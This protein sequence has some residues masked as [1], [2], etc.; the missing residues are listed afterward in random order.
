MTR[1][2]RLAY[3]TDQFLPSDGADTIQL[4]S[5]TSAFAAA[6][7]AVTLMP[8]APRRNIPDAANV[9]A[10]YGVAPGFGWHPLPGPYPALFRGL[11]KLLH[12]WKAARY[13]RGREID[14]VYTR[15]LPSLLAV[16]LLTGLPVFYE[17]YRPWPAQS[18]A[19]SLLFRALAR[20]RRFAGLI[21]HSALAAGSYAPLGYDEARL[22]VAHNGINPRLFE[23]APSRQEAR[24]RFGFDPDK[25]IAVY[26]G[27]VSPAKGLGL[28]LDAAQ[29]LP[30]LEFVLAGSTGEGAIEQRARGMGNVRVLGWQRPEAVIALLA[31]AD[32]LIIPPTAAPLQRTGNTVLPL[33]TFQYM[34]AGRAIVA[35]ATPDVM[36]VLADGSNARLVPPDQGESFVA[37]LR[38]L[39]ADP[40]LRARLGA[41]GREAALANSWQARAERVAGFIRNRL[42]SGAG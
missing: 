36:E 7:H 5:M 25:I 21:L 9:A 33:K 23:S 30:E 10:H 1:A 17:T 38:I 20:Q 37:A 13:L 16:L 34:A 42:A 19:K 39:A 12:G 14:A 40:A 2:L 8:P 15:N 4:V 22:L 31:A 35:P 32:I 24:A 29:R 41:A 26:A 18:A 6:G 28:V 27:H 11:E 3:V